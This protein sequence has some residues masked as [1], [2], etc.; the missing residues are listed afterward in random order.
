MFLPAENNLASVLVNVR[1][2]KNKNNMK[3]VIKIFGV[4]ILA[5]ATSACH[6]PPRPPRPPQPPRRPHGMLEKNLEQAK[7]DIIFE[8]KSVNKPS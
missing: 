3:S 7:A 4:F 2:P 5:Y 8:K 1:K 6:P